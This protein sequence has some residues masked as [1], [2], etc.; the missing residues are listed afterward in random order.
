MLSAAT[1]VIEITDLQHEYESVDIKL[2]ISRGGS[3]IIHKQKYYNVPLTDEPLPVKP[4]PA[5]L[6]IKLPDPKKI[7]ELSYVSLYLE[8]PAPPKNHQKVTSLLPDDG[9]TPNYTTLHDAVKAVLEADLGDSNAAI[10]KMSNLTGQQ[11]LHI[12]YEIL[13]GTTG[14]ARPEPKPSLERLYTDPEDDG[15]NDNRK[16][17]EVNLISYYSN[18]NSQSD[19]LANYVY[20]LSAA[21]WCEN[22][23]EEALNVGFIFP[24]LL[25]ALDRQSKVTLDLPVLELAANGRPP[26][27]LLFKVPAKYFYALGN[28][29]PP[30]IKPE[31]RYDIATSAPAE[32]N[33][34]IFQQTIDDNVI[35][36]VVAPDDVGKFQAARRLQ[37]LGLVKDTSSPRCELISGSKIHE[38]VNS[39]RDYDKQ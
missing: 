33:A 15:D 18:S 24:V 36:E 17:F 29:L 21:K 1:A 39:W 13:W 37:A 10:S 2:I 28:T 16:K 31:Q 14:A 23:S 19:R 20:S 3:E 35:T 5:D 9:T 4:D 30:Q 7:Q 34:T 27:T 38:L 12:A 11:A 6:N 8:L 32:Q 22:K 25:E 26:K